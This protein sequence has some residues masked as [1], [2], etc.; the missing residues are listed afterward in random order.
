MAYALW[1]S[2]PEEAREAF[3]NGE[4]LEV[5]QSEYGLNEHLFEFLRTRGWWDW[6]TAFRPRLGKE[7]GK[8]PAALNGAWVMVNL[9]HLGHLEHADP[10]L[11]DGKLM[12][13][14]G[15]TLREVTRSRKLE[16]GVVHRDTL[17]NHCKR[18]P[19]EE[20]ERVFYDSV[21]WQ[22][23]NKQLRGRWYAV[24]GF[25]L[26]VQGE[27]YEGAGIVWDPDENRWVRGY[28][29][30]LLLNVTPGRER[31][32]G[33]AMGP[34]QKDE[35]ALLEEI[36]AAMRAHGLEPKDLIDGL[37]FDRGYWGVGFLARLQAEYGLNWCTLV[38]AN[39]DLHAV[40]AKL[41]ASG[42][43]KLVPRTVRYRSGRQ[44]A[45]QVGSAEN[46]VAV[47]EKG[48]T[49]ALNVV[50]ARR[51]EGR[52]G[53]VQDRL[54]ATSL[55]LTELKPAR[56]IEKYSE[57]WA[58]ENEGIREFSQRWRARVPI[59]RSYS[60]IYAQLRMLAMCYNALR[61]YAMKRPKDA[62]VLQRECRRRARRSYLGGAGVLVFVLP[63]RIYAV[64]DGA[65][66]AL[67]SKERT[68][69]R[70]ETLLAAGLSPPEALRQVREE[71]M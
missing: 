28:K 15:F 39:V 24:D 55:P 48:D 43:L 57:R 23:R 20:S 9:A 63:R 42:H 35:R 65:E 50:L 8:S 19:V 10:L 68:L 34:I 67:L 29:V 38:P 2:A 41:V 18:I 33:L 5:V 66:V 54:F 46:L 12:L 11:R 45:L 44:E 4:P 52:T 64:M 49:L 47:G 13:E 6:L 37:I 26:E 56:V 3:R 31:I 32:V 27:H 14:A 30:V 7:N 69:R 61:D 60:A 53:E 70:I 1:R 58:V 16:K 59:A 71:R 17:R 22:R 51:V 21:A 40:V 25:R 62:E 36:L